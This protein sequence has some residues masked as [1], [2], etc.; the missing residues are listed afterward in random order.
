MNTNNQIQEN[1]NRLELK[2]KEIT[3]W[4]KARVVVIVALI[5]AMIQQRSVGLRRL[6]KHIDSKHDLKVRY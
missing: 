2:I 6:A 3:G 5:I 4:H 1:S